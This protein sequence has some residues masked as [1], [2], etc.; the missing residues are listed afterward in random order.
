MHSLSKRQL[1]VGRNKRSADPAWRV[2]HKPPNAG[3]ALRLFRPTNRVGMTLVEVVAGLIL[4]ATIGAGSV[5]AFGIHQRQI[6]TARETLVAT[7]LADRLLSRWQAESIPVPALQ[8]GVFNDHDW[9][10]R[11]QSLRAQAVAGLVVQVIRLDV[12]HR[13]RQGVL[14]RRTSVEVVAPVEGD[15]T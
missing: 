6:K 8:A 9:Q 15:G 14:H 1:D 7:Q 12:M 10:W 5:I 13:D 11:T 2:A 4:L 3:S